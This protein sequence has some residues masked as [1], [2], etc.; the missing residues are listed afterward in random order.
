[1]TTAAPRRRGA[2]WAQRPTGTESAVRKRFLALVQER[3]GITVSV[4]RG[5][6]QVGSGTMT[7]WIRKLRADGL[8]QC[9]RHGRR[10][11]LYPAGGPSKDPTSD[12]LLRGATVHGIAALVHKNPGIDLQRL[13]ALSGHGTRSV[14][15]HVQNLLKAGLVTSASATRLRELRATPKLSA[16]LAM[17]QQVGNAAP[18]ALPRSYSTG[19][20]P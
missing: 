8:I 20:N 14:Y 2:T 19:E 4:L 1:M 16:A 9:H 13:V 10:L 5:E 18:G 15:Y 12:A 3:P 7:Y 6:L 17:H 11:L